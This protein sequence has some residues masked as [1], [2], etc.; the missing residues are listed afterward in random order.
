MKIELT[1]LAKKELAGLSIIQE[2]L[3][4]SNISLYNNFTSYDQLLFDLEMFLSIVGERDIQSLEEFVLIISE[5]EGEE[6][7]IESVLKRLNKATLLELITI[8]YN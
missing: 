6:C 3:S 4:E 1:A 5:R 8:K 2:E 7:D